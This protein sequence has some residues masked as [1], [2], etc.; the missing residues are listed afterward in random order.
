MA[1]SGVSCDPR[2]WETRWLCGAEGGR[3]MAEEVRLWQIAEKDALVECGR[4]RLDL[5][6]R[7]ERWIAA[8]VSVL[9]PGL[10]VVGQQVPTESGGIID[11]LCLKEGGDLGGVDVGAANRVSPV[12]AL[13]TCDG[14]IRLDPRTAAMNDKSS[15]ASMPERD[16]A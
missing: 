12:A 9:D 10:M 4:S 2:P 8:D 14:R 16:R 1:P 11:L 5:E 7:L 13:D 15:R 6:A 3:G